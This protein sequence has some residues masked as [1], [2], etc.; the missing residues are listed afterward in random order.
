MIEFP[1]SGLREQR[2]CCKKEGQFGFHGFD[3]TRIP[4]EGLLEVP[5]AHP[6]GVGEA[7]NFHVPSVSQGP[8][9]LG[10]P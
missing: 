9:K 3:Q 6:R 2:G 5:G 10:N 7:D 1:S 4:A 8:Q